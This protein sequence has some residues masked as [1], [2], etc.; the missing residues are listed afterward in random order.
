MKS[1]NVDHVCDKCQGTLVLDREVDLLT[2]MTL[3]VSLCIN[4]GRRRKVEKDP[5]PLTAS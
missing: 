3:C 1:L 4:C 2:V 5:K